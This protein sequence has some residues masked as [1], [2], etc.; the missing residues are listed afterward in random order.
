MATKAVSKAAEAFRQV[1]RVRSL[2]QPLWSSFEES[3]LNGQSLALNWSL[4]KHD[5]APVGV[6]RVYRN[7]RPNELVS[8]CETRYGSAFA[9]AL[10]SHDNASRRAG[11]MQLLPPRS[12]RQAHQMLVNSYLCN[13]AGLRGASESALYVLDGAFGSNLDTCV[14]SRVLCDDPVVALALT[15]LMERLPAG[16]LHVDAFN[17]DVVA[18]VATAYRGSFDVSGASP[19]TTSNPQKEQT[20]ASRANHDASLSSVTYLSTDGSSVYIGSSVDLDHMRYAI[21]SAAATVM[22][23]S[24]RGIDPERYGLVLRGHV[25]PTGNAVLGAEGQ[26]FLWTRTGLARGWRDVLLLEEWQSN[27]AN[28]EVTRRQWRERVAVP[29]WPYQGTNTKDVK[30][31]AIAPRRASLTPN[32]VPGPRTLFLAIDSASVKSASTDATKKKKK[33]TNEDKGQDLGVRLVRMTD[34]KAI[35]FYALA[36]DAFSVPENLLELVVQD[37][38]GACER[39]NVQSILVVGPDAKS[40]AMRLAAEAS[41]PE[42]TA[43]TVPLECLRFAQERILE[44]Y[45]TVGPRLISGDGILSSMQTP[46]P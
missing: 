32:L 5:A 42:P 2:R 24:R 39:T 19:L 29:R 37:F 33:S 31:I 13:S 28:Q 1:T 6:E 27:V 10:L 20:T 18:Y 14:V 12:L 44:R 35:T 4:A 26:H 11:S 22:L 46:K 3:K 23:S 36:A 15:H 7:L 43:E 25:Y 9:A 30:S 17:P 41:L 38:L 8:H 45:R 34:P 40:R 16:A 21:A